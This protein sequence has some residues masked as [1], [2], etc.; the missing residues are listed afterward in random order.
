MTQKHI[1][2][3]DQGITFSRAIIF[4]AAI[5]VVAAAQQEFPQHSPRSAWVEHDPQDLW[6]TTLSKSRAALKKA[7]LTAADIAAIG[8]TNQRDACRAHDAL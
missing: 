2:A 7:S 1:L 4:D 8:I 5:K 3:L 6:Q